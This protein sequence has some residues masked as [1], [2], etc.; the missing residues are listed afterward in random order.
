[1]YNIINKNI[2]TKTIIKPIEA[3]FTTKPSLFNIIPVNIKI[4]GITTAMI[5]K[6]ENH[7]GIRNS[8]NIVSI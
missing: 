5:N 8:T 7:A 3:E 6:I 2:I 4:N 1:M